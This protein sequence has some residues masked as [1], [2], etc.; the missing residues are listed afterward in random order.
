MKVAFAG[1]VPAALA[2]RVRARLTIPCE[3]IVDDEPG[4]IAEYVIGAMISLTCSFCRLD[5][6]LRRGE[7]ESRWAVGRSPPP[8]R[9]DLKGKTLAILGL[10]HIGR[11]IARRAHAFDMRI[12]AIR[13]DTTA[14]K[15]LEVAEVCGLDQLEHVLR[16]ADFVVLTLPLVAE[17][18]NLI[19]AARL[20]SMKPTA[21]LINV[22]RGEVVDEA[23]L[24]H[25]L[26]EK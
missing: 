24:Y 22:A 14:T 20:R 23:A 10:G 9:T 15:P 3:L 8:L 4:V 18:T 21:F 2:E 17:T 7:W 16:E 19:D 6:K 25:A 13:R 11:E 1:R 12:T 26:A 5:M